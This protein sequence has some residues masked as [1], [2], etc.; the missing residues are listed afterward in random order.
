MF[1]HNLL[2]VLVQIAN[3][4]GLQK[5]ITETASNRLGSSS[6]A[7]PFMPKDMRQRIPP[8]VLHP[9]PIIL[10]RLVADTTHNELYEK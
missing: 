2:H 6:W 9:Q 3:K 4:M 1:L 7:I 8:T 5:E 10:I